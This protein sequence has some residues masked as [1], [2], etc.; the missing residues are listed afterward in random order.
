MRHR[1]Q[2]VGSR[3]QV[4]AAAANGEVVV[5]TVA[6]IILD[7][8]TSQPEIALNAQVLLTQARLHQAV[9]RHRCHF[10]P[11][12]QR[13][14]QRCQGHH[15]RHSQRRSH[16]QCQRHSQHRSRRLWCNLNALQIARM[17]WEWTLRGAGRAGILKT[18]ATAIT[19]KSRKN[20]RNRVGPAAKALAQKRKG[21]ALPGVSAAQSWRR[22]AIAF[23]AKSRES[24]RNRVGT[25]GRATSQGSETKA[26]RF[27]SYLS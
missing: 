3:H 2:V 27:I 4:V 20:A 17:P 18:R 11:L 19:L 1:H 25:A 5:V 13:W 22:L 10:H 12:H 24:A 7:G 6:T 23:T 16:R 8:V 14:R 21:T 26:D 9:A 15:P